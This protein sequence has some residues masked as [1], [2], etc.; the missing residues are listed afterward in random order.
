MPRRSS[1][2]TTGPGCEEEAVDRSDSTLA[3]KGRR[4]PVPSRTAV[5]NR[6]AL[7]LFLSSGPRRGSGSRD[8]RTAH[9]R[10]VLRPPDRRHGRRDRVRRGAGDRPI[11]PARR[12]PG[13]SSEQDPGGGGPDGP[14]AYRHCGLCRHRSAW[15]TRRSTWNSPRGSD[16]TTS[17]GGP[18]P[19]PRTR[20]RGRCRHGRGP[21]GMSKAET[22]H[23]H[24]GH[25][26]FTWGHVHLESDVL[27]PAAHR[28][29]GGRHGPRPP[30]PRRGARRSRRRP[31]RPTRVSRRIR[32]AA[33]KTPRS[34]P[35]GVTS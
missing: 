21:R 3:S 30:L 7:V 20:P 6:S 12:I 33:R 31:S 29:W 14:D 35:P 24:G 22:G 25:V 16:T 5:E 32:S 1:Q 10:S 23:R 8:R 17:A 15:P 27:T 9:R 28:L 19:T 2:A 34:S 4:G 18:R 26:G 13:W 11:R